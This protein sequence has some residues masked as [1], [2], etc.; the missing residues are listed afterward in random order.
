M[1]CLSPW[2]WLFSP[3]FDVTSWRFLN[4]QL[5]A[6]CV[7]STKNWLGANPSH[8][9]DLNKVRKLLS[10]CDGSAVSEGLFWENSLALCW[11][12]TERAALVLTLHTAKPFFAWHKIRSHWKEL[13]CCNFLFLLLWYS[14]WAQDS[15]KSVWLIFFPPSFLRLFHT[16]EDCLFHPQAPFP[17]SQA[18][19]GCQFMFTDPSSWQLSDWFLCN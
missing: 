5:N 7:F 18:D 6:C 17:S 13:P 12:H 1:H 2:S 3:I 14:C 8:L 15:H 16:F 19:R 9:K 4:P 11:Q 10:I